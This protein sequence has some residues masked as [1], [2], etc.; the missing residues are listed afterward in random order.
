[1]GSSQPKFSVRLKMIVNVSMKF[2]IGGILDNKV[3]SGKASGMRKQNRI[4]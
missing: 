2:F 4:S 1:M 3:V